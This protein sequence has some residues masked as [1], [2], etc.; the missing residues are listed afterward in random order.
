MSSTLLGATQFGN[1]TGD[2]LNNFPGSTASVTEP[3]F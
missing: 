2:N 3:R 1:Q